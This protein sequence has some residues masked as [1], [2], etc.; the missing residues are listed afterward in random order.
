MRIH[1]VAFLAVLT[2][3]CTGVVKPFTVHNE[4]YAPTGL[5][6]AVW[7]SCYNTARA[8]AT[9]HKFN[10][11]YAKLSWQKSHCLLFEVADQCAMEILE[12]ATKSGDQVIWSDYDIVDYEEAVAK[13]VEQCKAEETAAVDALRRRIIEDVR[14]QWRETASGLC[15]CRIAG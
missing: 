8:S 12:I 10:G 1:L 6:Q 4:S 3:A 15:S 11:E 13:S 9:S 2:T 7:E 14:K 5:P